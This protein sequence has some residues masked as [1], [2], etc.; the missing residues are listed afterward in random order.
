M[1]RTN[2]SSSSDI[3]NDVRSPQDSAEDEKYNTNYELLGSYTLS[4]SNASSSG[5]ASSFSSLYSGYSRYSGAY[6]SNSSVTTMEGSSGYTQ[7]IAVGFVSRL[8]SEEDFLHIGSQFSRGAERQA[9]QPHRYLHKTAPSTN[10]AE[11]DQLQP[12]YGK[13]CV[14]MSQDGM[15]EGSVAGAEQPKCVG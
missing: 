8:G 6:T 9:L 10:T 11:F 14:L 3:A 4:L 5:S 1:L 7:P 12:I 2:R 15:M 13:A